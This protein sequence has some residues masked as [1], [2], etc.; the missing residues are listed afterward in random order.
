M[1]HGNFE[2]ATNLS[3][4][5]ADLLIPYTTY[6]DVECVEWCVKVADL[7]LIRAWNDTAKFKQLQDITESMCD[8]SFNGHGHDPKACKAIFV[9]NLREVITV[10]RALAV[11]CAWSQFLF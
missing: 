7:L 4:S 10:G 9:D 1:A 6:M 11:R 3:R 5:N 2:R 8:L